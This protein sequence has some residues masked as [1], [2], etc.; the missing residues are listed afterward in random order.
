VIAALIAISLSENGK[1]MALKE[2]RT[3]YED[4]FK[5]NFSGKSAVNAFTGIKVEL[6]NSGLSKTLSQGK[7]YYFSLQ[8]VR[9]EE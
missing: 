1:K 7:N 6:V 9:L 2:L 4:F 3:Y 8:D 5:T